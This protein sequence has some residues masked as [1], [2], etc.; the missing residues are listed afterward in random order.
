M[1]VAT[2]EILPQVLPNPT[3]P[4]S[5]RLGNL[6]LT[7]NEVLEFAAP[8]TAKARY[9]VAKNNRSVQNAKGA[10]AEIGRASCRERV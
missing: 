1:A 7:P 3:L 5:L 10:L 6:E 4:Q 9:E 2:V 8:L